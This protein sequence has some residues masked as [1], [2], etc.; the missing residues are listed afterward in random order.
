MEE[1]RHTLLCIL[2]LFWIIIS[3]KFVVTPDFLFWIPR[4]LAKFCFLCIVLLVYNLPKPDSFVVNVTCN[5]L[6]NVG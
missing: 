6:I 4:A 3:E 1:K 5:W 2:L